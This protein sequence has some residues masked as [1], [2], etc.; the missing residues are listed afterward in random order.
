[1][2]KDKPR[3]PTLRTTQPQ[4]L[5]DAVFAQAQRDEMT[6]SAWVGECLVAN[7]DQ[8]LKETVPE[9]RPAHRPKM[10]E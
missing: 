10:D 8:D 4:E 2:A 3:Q 9:R 7:L 6:V 1:M 5:I